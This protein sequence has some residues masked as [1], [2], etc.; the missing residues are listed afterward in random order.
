MKV[1]ERTETGT[2]NQRDCLIKVSPGDGSVVVNSK[3]EW[4]F[5]KHIKAIV[6]EKIKE[7]ELEA[8]IEVEENGAIDYVIIARLEAAAA[9]ATMSD[10]PCKK[11]RRGKTA[12][13]R[14]RRSRLYIPGN[15]P[16]FINNVEIYGSD[17]IILDLEDSVSMEQKHDARNLVKNA[18]S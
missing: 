18:L 14:P 8:N 16:R 2:T 15:N 4:M 5:E 6:T 9:Q 10:I 13:D 3:T 1:I 17:Y 12:K 11:T 7:L